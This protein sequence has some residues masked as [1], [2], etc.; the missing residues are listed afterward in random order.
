MIVQEL[1]DV[2]SGDPDAELRLLVPSGHLL[3][4]QYG[5]AFSFEKWDDKQEEDIDQGPGVYLVAGD[6]EPLVKHV[7]DRLF[8]KANAVVVED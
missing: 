4:I 8:A 1:L 7:L 2:M 6:V 3:P 5:V